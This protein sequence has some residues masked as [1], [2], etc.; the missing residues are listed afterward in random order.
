YRGDLLDRRYRLSRDQ[1][2]RVVVW[3]YEFDDQGNLAKTT[4]PDGSEEINIFDVAHTDPRMRS[5]LLKKERTSASGFPSPS[6]IVW[7]GA[8]E[9]N[10]QQLKEEKDETG[11]ST[12]YRYDY[13]VSPAAAAN[14]GKLIEIIHPDTTLPDGTVQKAKERF[15]YNSK[16]Q[17]TAN[18]KSDGT[19]NEFEYGT[20]GNE[21]SRLIKQIFDVENLAIEHQ[22]K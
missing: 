18:I 17:I 1:S 16:G 12:T 15:E 7:R 4:N 22:M 13:D 9:A 21:K 20:A 8:Y 10:T 14:T 5:N 3:Q 19:R 6:R 11:A 2:F